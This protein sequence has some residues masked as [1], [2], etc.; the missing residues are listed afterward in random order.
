MKNLQ[1]LIIVSVAASH[2]TLL[3]LKATVLAKPRQVLSKLPLFKKLLACP[4]CLGWWIAMATYMS[5]KLL[6][7]PIEVIAVAGLAHMIYLYRDK[8]L[9]CP[10]CEKPVD[11]GYKVV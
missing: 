1:M 6:P 4:L 5:A 9:P 3:L 2:L 11:N 8:N 7:L 10:D